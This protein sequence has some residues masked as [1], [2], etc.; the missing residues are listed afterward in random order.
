MVSNIDFAIDQGSYKL[1]LAR[2]AKEELLEVYHVVAVSRVDAG[3][4]VRVLATGEPAL[5]L[6]REDPQV[7]KLIWPVQNG[8]VKEP[9]LAEKLLFQLR[10]YQSK[11]FF[12]RRPRVL[13]AMPVDVSFAEKW[14]LFEVLVHN[15]HSPQRTFQIEDLLAVAVGAGLDFN[16]LHPQ[17]LLHIGAGYSAIGVLMPEVSSRE[18]V[19]RRCLRYR[20]YIPY[21]GNWLDNVIQRYVYEKYEVLLSWHVCQQIKH[22]LGTLT[23]G[24]SRAWQGMGMLFGGEEKPLCLLS[25]EVRQSLE[26]GLAVICTEIEWFM[27]ELPPD[28]MMACRHTGIVLSGGTAY[29]PGIQSWLADRLALPVQISEAP[30]LLVIR[31]LEKLLPKLEELRTQAMAENQHRYFYVSSINGAV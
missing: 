5:D 31:G 28:V 2:P 12:I 14:Q 25:T 24:L 18:L 3:K 20:K 7:V 10:R 30:D 26:H 4:E 8:V 9:E 21:A 23:S 22:E 1:R 19:Q 6:K 17:L 29:L 11:P 16:V 15:F 27:R 13:G